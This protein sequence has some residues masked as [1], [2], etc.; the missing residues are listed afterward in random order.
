MKPNAE[1][2]IVP[3]PVADWDAAR[4]AESFKAFARHVHWQ[5]K[6]ILLRDGRHV[7][8]LFFMPLDGNGHVVLWRSD[9]RDI[10]A[11]W[12]RRHV[13]EHYAYGIVRVVE[14]WARFAAGPSDHTLRQIVDG[15]I[16]VSELRPGDRKEVLMVSAQSRDGWANSWNDEILR[17]QGG[18]PIFGACLEVSD[19][20]GRFG[21]V[22]G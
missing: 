1:P 19:F 5:A 3:L 21:S 10:E 9:D 8:M 17:G 20:R 12:L 11:D 13:R 15:E 7:E 6:E 4:P 14:A 22:F 18:K 2:K 16:K